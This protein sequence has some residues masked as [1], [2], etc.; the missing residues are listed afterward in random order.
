MA[1]NYYKG[2]FEGYLWKSDKQAPTIYK[3]DNLLHE[4]SFDDEKNPFIIEGQLFD[5]TTGHSLSIKYVDGEYK[6]KEYYVITSNEEKTF[7]EVKEGDKVE[8]ECVSKEL[9]YRGSS[10]MEGNNLHF[11]ELWEEESD[12]ACCNM[13]VLNA[14]KVIFAGFE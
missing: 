13:K 11:Y 7:F 5:K 10:R 4:R 8:I 14:T 12:P 3:G 9:Y 6:I 2:N 1:T